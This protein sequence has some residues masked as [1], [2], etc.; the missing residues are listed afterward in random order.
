MLL[1]FLDGAKNGAVI[2]STCK[3]I[4]PVRHL[5]TLM[6]EHMLILEVRVSVKLGL[7]Q[8]G[9]GYLPIRMADA[10]NPRIAR[11]RVR[12][13]SVVAG[14]TDVPKSG[15]LGKGLFNF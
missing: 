9:K 2:D 6:S 8:T 14:G 15:C 3:S 10:P 11:Y 13:P 12:E 5:V 4:A 7:A 1:E